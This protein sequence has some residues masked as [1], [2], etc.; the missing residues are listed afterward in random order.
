M[1]EIR[2]GQA[3]NGRTIAARVGDTIRIELE[4]SPTT[5]YRWAL[6]PVDAAI[7]DLQGDSFQQ[8]GTGIGGAGTRVFRLAARSRAS[9]DLEFRLARQWETVAPRAEFSV[10]IAIS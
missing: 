9:M 7:A 3:D 1:A 6:S 8:H 5:G 4:E 10:H 2:V